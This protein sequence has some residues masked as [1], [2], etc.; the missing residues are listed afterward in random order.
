MKFR[1][2]HLDDGTIIDH[3]LVLTENGIDTIIVDYEC[4]LLE[5]NIPRFPGNDGIQVVDFLTNL[6]E[7]YDQ[8]KSLAFTL[9]YSQDYILSDSFARFSLAKEAGSTADEALKCTPLGK[10]A[11]QLG[12]SRISTPIVNYREAYVRFYKDR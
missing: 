9:K 10:A 11:I 12:F 4:S 7:H 8:V 2:E 1:Q 6:L 3:H 5:L